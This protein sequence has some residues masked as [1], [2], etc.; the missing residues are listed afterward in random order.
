M[1]E[2]W[3]DL[4]IQVGP[5]SMVWG[6][7][8]RIRYSRSADSH[9]LQIRINPDI[10]KNEIKARLVKPGL[11]EIEWPRRVKGEEIPVD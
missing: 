2:D 11:L 3:E 8:R 5:F 6:T 4:D 9:I 7:R 1:F 10:Q